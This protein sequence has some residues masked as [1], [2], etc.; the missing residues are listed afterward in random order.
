MRH[1]LKWTQTGDYAIISS[2]LFAGVGEL[3]KAF[4][5]SAALT[6]TDP[7]FCENE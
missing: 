6:H 5:A 4:F 3:S 1:L 7:K 2:D